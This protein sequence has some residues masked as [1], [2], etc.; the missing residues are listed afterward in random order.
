MKINWKIKKPQIIFITVLLLGEV[1][2]WFSL[3]NLNF[4]LRFV[5]LVISTVLMLIL[6]ESLYKE[7]NAKGVK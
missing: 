1:Y 4:V 3:P 2:L 6:G 7:N 5:I